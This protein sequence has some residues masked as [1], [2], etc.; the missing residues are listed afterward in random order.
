MVII[1]CA[2]LFLQK[3]NADVSHW[4]QK[5]KI[6]PMW[7]EAVHMEHRRIPPL[8]IVTSLQTD[9]KMR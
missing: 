4:N 7:H 6:L 5:A 9:E 1:T 8:L 3:E 2:Y